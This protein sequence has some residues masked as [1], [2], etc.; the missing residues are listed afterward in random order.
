MKADGTLWTWG[1]NSNG[2]LGDG[3]TTN[4]T[5]P[6]RV[7]SD[8]DWATAAAD[9]HTLV[10]KTDGTLWAWGQ[11][12]A[13]ELGDG[14]TTDRH[15]P[16]RIGTA[17]NWVT[18]AA[19]GFSSH[20]V[21]T[22]GT[23]WGWGYNSYGELCLRHLQQ[24]RAGRDPN[25]ES[26]QDREVPA[27]GHHPGPRRRH[28]GDQPRRAPDDDR[29]DCVPLDN[30]AFTGDSITFRAT[31]APSTQAVNAPTGSVTFLDGTTPIGSA[32]IVGGVASFSTTTLALGTHTITASYDG[33]ADY[34]PSQQSLT[35][36]VNLRPTLMSLTVVRQEV[37][38]SARRSRSP[39]AS[40]RVELQRASPPG[41]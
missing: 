25:P 32:S 24:L 30:P 2:Q 11:N 22:D 34:A 28:A 37:A 26:D 20:A 23:A 4:R 27:V 13:A 14:S 15:T 33:D 8:S 35:Q 12:A 1:Y 38:T 5:S 3:T 39:Q 36:V 40:K 17:A 10:V 41:P 21:R 29:D 31:V 18:V 19:G 7:G 16:T 6:G 9:T